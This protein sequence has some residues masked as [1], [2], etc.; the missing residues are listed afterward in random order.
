MKAQVMAETMIQSR[1]MIAQ[2]PRV[3]DEAAI[4]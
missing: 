4:R 2:Y 1:F 3:S